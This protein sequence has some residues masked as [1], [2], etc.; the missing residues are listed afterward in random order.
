M[1]SSPPLKAYDEALC[2]EGDPAFQCFYDAGGAGAGT[3]KLRIP[4][5]V[6]VLAEGTAP[7]RVFPMGKCTFRINGGEKITTACLKQGFAFRFFFEL[8]EVTFAVKAERNGNGNSSV[9]KRRESIL[10]QLK[11]FSF[12]CAPLFGG[13]PANGARRSHREN[14]VTGVRQH[15]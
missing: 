2:S 8:I 4:A 5:V 3:E 9:I 7:K 11:S 12:S 6:L 15:H 1:R 10:F 13:R 14:T